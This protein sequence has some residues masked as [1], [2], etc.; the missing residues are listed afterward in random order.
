MVLEA[1]SPRA[2]AAFFFV[3]AIYGRRHLSYGKM[4][5]SWNSRVSSSLVISVNPF[6]KLGPN[7]LNMRLGLFTLL[8]QALSLWH[9]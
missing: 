3:S 1:Q 4:E 8:Y 5:T 6:M 7:K 2:T 9:T